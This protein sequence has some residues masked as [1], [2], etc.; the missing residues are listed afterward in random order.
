MYTKEMLMNDKH[1][2]RNSIYDQTMKEKDNFSK[3]DLAKL[4]QGH[5]FLARLQEDLKYAVDLGEALSDYLRNIADYFH[6]DR[7]VILETDLTKGTNTVNYQWNSKEENTLV[8][9]FQ[10][11]TE[12]SFHAG[13]GWCGNGTENTGIRRKSESKYSD[14]R[15]DC[16]CDGRCKISTAIERNE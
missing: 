3:E 6:L 16:R 12:G 5:Q 1:R 4:A 7:I 13:Y 8:D 15:P 9:Y 2:K 14:Y 10:T 11:M